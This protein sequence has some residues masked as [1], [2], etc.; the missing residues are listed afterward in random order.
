M[1]A[2]SS[3]YSTRMSEFP[4]VEVDSTYF[5]MPSENTARLGATRTGEDFLFDV[6]AV[7]EKNI[8][9]TFSFLREKNIPFVCVDKY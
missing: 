4:I 2:S 3:P 6:K 5:G 1:K 7:N 8:E 9:R